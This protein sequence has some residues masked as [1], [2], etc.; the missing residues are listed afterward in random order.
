MA[1][2]LEQA[3]ERLPNSSHIYIDITD[4]DMEQASAL[5]I[6]DNYFHDMDANI[7]IL[8]TVAPFDECAEKEML[9]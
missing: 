8:G 6:V 1:I 5:C 3:K 4:K 2:T 9:A 7:T